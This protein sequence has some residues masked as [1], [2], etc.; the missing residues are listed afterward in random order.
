MTED[1]QWQLR[2][3]ELIPT[4]YSLGKTPASEKKAFDPWNPGAGDKVDFRMYMLASD[5]IH[6]LE[7]PKEFPILVS[8]L[9]QS[10][11]QRNAGA[12]SVLLAKGEDY[13]LQYATAELSGGT[14]THITPVSLPT[15]HNLRGIVASPVLSL[16]QDAGFAGAAFP[17][18]VES[19]V[20][21]KGSRRTSVISPSGASDFT[22]YPLRNFD[23]I[24]DVTATYLG[25]HARAQFTLTKYQIQFHDFNQQST[26]MLSQKRFS[27]LPAIFA[28]KSFF[29]VVAQNAL[30]ERIPALFVPG[31]F[32]FSKAT[33]VILPR[34]NASG[35]LEA[36]TRPAKFHLESKPGCTALA[37]AKAADASGSSELVFFCGD[38]F[39]AF[40][41]N[42]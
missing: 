31:D 4:W 38:R 16:N 30:Q 22:A 13:A 3:G 6:S 28:I 26:V 14:W 41:L 19:D 25:D 20:G 12:V 21:P 39:L 24:T 17:G 8:L 10:T 7:L 36:L 34:Y 40:P 11:A 1:F 5:G 29:P 42:Y 33:Q 37:S 18:F 32:V 23:A 27:F 2:Q 15:Y 35:K 9:P